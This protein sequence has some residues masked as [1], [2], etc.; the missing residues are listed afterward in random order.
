MSKAYQ[1]NSSS[2]NIYNY[3]CFSNLNNKPSKA[4]DLLFELSSKGKGDLNYYRKLAAKEKSF[5]SL[6]SNAKFTR[7]LSGYRRLEIKPHTA[8]SNVSDGLFNSND[9]FIVIENEGRIILVTDVV[10]ESNKASWYSEKVVFDYPLGSQIRFILM[11]ED[12]IEHDKFVDVRGS[13]TKTGNQKYRRGTSYMEIRISDTER[14]TYTSG[15]QLPSEVTL[16]ELAL[17]AG[18]VYLV[19]N[20]NEL[21][22][23]FFTRLIDCSTKAGIN[24]FVDNPLLAAAVEE[25]YDSV[26]KRKGYSFSGLSIN[27]VKGLVINE[28]KNS[29]HKD[30]ANMLETADYLYCVFSN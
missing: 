9:L 27:A 12:I 30:A 28:L 5:I 24:Q 14:S 2:R 13:I 21:D 3:A 15:T 29:G 6:R 17:G 1:F 11:D 16:K 22:N 19:A 10:Q 26:R 7:F 18:F 8:F 20:S 23:S 4:M 25:A